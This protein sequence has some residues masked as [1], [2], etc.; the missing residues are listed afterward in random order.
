MCRCVLGQWDGVTK[1]MIRVGLKRKHTHCW[2]A[3]TARQV[4]QNLG[5]TVVWC[6]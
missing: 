2:P 5:Q 1:Q 3:G 4:T 6:R